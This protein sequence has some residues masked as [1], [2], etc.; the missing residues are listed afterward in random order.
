MLGKIP[1]GGIWRSAKWFWVNL[2]R[3]MKFLLE[4]FGDDGILSEE[5]L[6]CWL[7]KFFLKKSRAA[8]VQIRSEEILGG[9]WSKFFLKKFRAAMVQI[10]SEEILIRRGANS[11]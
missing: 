3:V 9:L 11:F 8:V 2:F 10:R 6:G 4:Q 5:I 7:C 1:S